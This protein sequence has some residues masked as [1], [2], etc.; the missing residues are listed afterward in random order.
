MP[1]RGRWGSRPAL[2]PHP[3]V[4]RGRTGAWDASHP[5]ICHT[6]ANPSRKLRTLTSGSCGVNRRQH[7]LHPLEAPRPSRV[8]HHCPLQAGGPFWFASFWDSW[9]DELKPCILLI[10]NANAVVEWVRGGT[11]DRPTRQ[12]GVN[13]DLACSGPRSSDRLGVRDDRSD[14]VM[15]TASCGPGLRRPHRVPCLPLATCGATRP[16]QGG[17]SLTNRPRGYPRQTSASI[18]TISSPCYSSCDL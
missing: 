1:P 5:Q 14:R 10:T 2:G 3:G 16:P 13:A 8:P 4:W 7:R 12:A 9:R 18:D 15:L 11:G 6:R 17:M